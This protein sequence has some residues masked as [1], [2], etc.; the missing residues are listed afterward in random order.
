M[1]I[2]YPFGHHTPY[3]YDGKEREDTIYMRLKEEES[4]WRRGGGGGGG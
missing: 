3:A 2:L 1:A 4:R